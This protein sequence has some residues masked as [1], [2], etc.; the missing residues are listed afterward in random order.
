M[1]TT[2][3]MALAL[4]LVLE[5]VLPFLIPSVWRDVNWRWL[6][7]MAAAVRRTSNSVFT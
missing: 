2:L 5:G 6:T 1:Q 3:W 7:P 4:M